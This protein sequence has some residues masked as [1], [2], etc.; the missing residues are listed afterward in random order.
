MTAELPAGFEDLTD[1]LDWALPTE[2][3]RYVK[4]MNSS[5]EEL[6]AFYSRVLPRAPAAQAYLDRLDPKALPPDA[7]RL[8]LLLFSMII[9]S[10]AVDV[11]DQPLVP[12]SG[13]A[14]VWRVGDP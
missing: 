7:Q 6:R 10:Y 3:E 5:I 12:D 11:F 13:S 9:V 8:L 2:E 14:Y 4:R 1:L